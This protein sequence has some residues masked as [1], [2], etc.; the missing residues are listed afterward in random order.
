MYQS[1]LWVEKNYVV[2]LDCETNAVVGVFESQNL[3]DHSHWTMRQNDR[4][5][6][7]LAQVT[8]VVMVEMFFLVKLLIQ[9]NE[10]KLL[11]HPC[12]GAN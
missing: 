11:F 10:Q 9:L 12:N 8:V 6:V 3:M 1:V 5:E 4:F 7:D 2:C